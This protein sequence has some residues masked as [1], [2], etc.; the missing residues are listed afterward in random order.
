MCAKKKRRS[1][2][3]DADKAAARLTALYEQ[4]ERDISARLTRALAATDGDKNKLTIRALEQQHKA[5]K[6]ILKQLLAKTKKP[7]REMVEG[8]FNGGL[9]V[10]RKELKEAGMTD[11]VLE[12]GGVNARAMKVYSEQIYSRMADVVQQA[13]RT[14]T[15]IYQALK[16]DTGLGG[17][18]G[19]YDAIGNV[20]RNMQKVSEDVGITA[21]IDKRGRSWNMASYTDMLCRTSSMQI[22]H[23]AKTNEYLAHGEDLVIVTSH[24]PTCAKC[25]PWNGRILSLTGETPGF[26]TMDEARAAGLFHP[27]CRHTYGLYIQEEELN[28]EEKHA[29]NRYVSSDSYKINEKLRTRS[30]LTDDEKQFINL[31]DK[32]L[33][34][35]PD[36]QGTFYRNITLDMVSDDKF[37]SFVKEHEVGKSVYYRGYTSASKDKEGY[38]IT[39]DKIVSITMNVKHGK[40]INQFGYGVPEEQ[41]VIL[42]RRTKFD[43]IKAQLKDNNLFLTMEEKG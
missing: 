37:K 35:L 25:A 41:E 29:L 5:V 7:V 30:Q 31:L 12:M 24:T 20:R 8:A 1:G 10:A 18:V 9:A 43:I 11:V 17:A 38:T 16:L 42:R 23:Q 3:S 2:L 21:F 15:D 34:K 28:I 36:Y 32:A 27:N 6:K 14:T 4:A 26:P 22:F 19:G 33:D 39:G 40:D 13:N